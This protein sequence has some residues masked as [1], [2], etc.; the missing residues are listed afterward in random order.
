[1]THDRRSLDFFWSVRGGS[2]AHKMVVKNRGNHADVDSHPF[3][4][5]GQICNLFSTH[6]S[7]VGH[8]QLFVKKLQLST[9]TV[10]KHDAAC[11]YLT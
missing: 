9:T 11:V 1:M 3:L 10:S 6:F 2:E 5:A 4:G 8:L 7:Y